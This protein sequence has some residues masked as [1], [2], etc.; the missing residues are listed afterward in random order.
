MS[1][2]AA[3]AE[4]RPVLGRVDGEGRLVVADPA[5]FALHR[6]AGG[7]EGG[8]LAVPQIAALARLSRRLGIPISRAAIAADGD[9]DVDL[10][11]RAEPEGREVAL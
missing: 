7:K 8:V 3:M 9:R 6:R 2:G 10:W 4:P 5:L 1:G 11:V